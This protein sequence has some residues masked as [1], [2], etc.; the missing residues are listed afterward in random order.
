[1]TEIPHSTSTEGASSASVG[2]DGPPAETSAWKPYR[3]FKEPELETAIKSIDPNTAVVDWSYADVWDPY[4]MGQ[5]LAEQIGREY[6]V[7]AP[8]NALWIWFGDLPQDM[9]EVLLKKFESELAFPAG[10]F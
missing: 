7:R 5:C 9:R 8:A 3:P 2:H 4:G 1:M 6:Y 10:L